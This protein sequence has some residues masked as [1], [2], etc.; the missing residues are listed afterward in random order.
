MKNDALLF[1]PVAARRSRL[2]AVLLLTL[3]LLVSI[4]APTFAAPQ[5]G[6]RGGRPV[7]S[8]AGSM[9]RLRGAFRNSLPRIRGQGKR[10]E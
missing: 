5:R 3:S 10:E 7:T 1:C 6:G 4:A 9:E 2:V 8:P